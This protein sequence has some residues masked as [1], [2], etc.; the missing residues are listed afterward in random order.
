[1]KSERV[2]LCRPQGGLNDILCT[3]ER[4]RAYAGKF[5]RTLFVDT[6]FAHTDY[7]RDDFSNYFKSKDRTIHLDTSPIAHLLDQM[8]TFPPCVAGRI[9]RYRAYFDQALEN[10]AE[11]ETRQ[12][13]SFNPDADYAEQLLVLHACGGGALGVA[14][15]SRLQLIDDLA[16]ELT[17]RLDAIGD[18]YLGLHIRH[19]DYQ[20]DYQ[21]SLAAMTKLI[22]DAH[23]A[24]LFVATDNI[25][26]LN[27]CRMLFSSHKV[28]SFS[29]LPETPGTVMHCG[30][31]ISNRFQRNA[32]AILDVI[33]LSLANRLFVLPLAPGQPVPYSGFSFLAH[34]LKNNTAVL[35]SLVPE[36][37][38]RR[39]FVGPSTL[40]QTTGTRRNASCPC[41]SGKRYKHCCGF[42]NS[43][44]S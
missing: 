29:W 18:A 23:C 42:S 16:E 27:Y 38:A 24:N 36:V 28:F 30:S 40:A 4:A 25:E 20:S 41:G 34:N 33:M 17:R 44:G 2:L 14:A 1:M 31:D 39:N 19:T 43:P 21:H 11:Q 3:I 6:N 8:T 9:N 15:L 26:C 35:K 37:F 22:D 12:A 32:D 7:M 5:N 13:I 10:F